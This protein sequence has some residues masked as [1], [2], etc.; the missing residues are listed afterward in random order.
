[1]ECVS[2]ASAHPPASRAPGAICIGHDTGGL[3]KMPGVYF[4]AQVCGHTLHWSHAPSLLSRGSHHRTRD[5]SGSS[6]LGMPRRQS[7]CPARTRLNTRTRCPSFCAAH[8]FA[9]SRPV[10]G[11][12]PEPPRGAL[13]GRRR[14]RVRPDGA[15]ARGDGRRR[16]G[17]AVP[18]ARYD[19]RLH[20][21]V[22][23]GELGAWA[24]TARVVV[25]QP[26]LVHT[27]AGLD[28]WQSEIALTPLAAHTY[29]LNPPPRSDRRR[30]PGDRG[31]AH[32]QA[33]PPRR[34][35]PPRVLRPQVGARQQGRRRRGG[36]QRARLQDRHRREPLGR[37]RLG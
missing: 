23:K 10:E 5:C 15:S 8:V 33:P 34:A 37:Q 26:A 35:R 36:A 1:M 11:H 32:R 7:P 22:A 4:K 20:G 18:G 16:A 3:G 19:G 24:G 28:C 25:Q 14:P 30:L 13:G 17:A 2:H 21:G 6:P 29:H 9:P 27:Q 12:A 31:V